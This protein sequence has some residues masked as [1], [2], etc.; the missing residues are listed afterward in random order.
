VDE[1]AKAAKIAV[2]RRRVQKPKGEDHEF[3]AVFQKDLKVDRK[4]FEGI[5][6]NLLDSKP[7]KRENV[8]V[9]KKKPGKLIPPPK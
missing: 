6:K 9:G 8:K 3:Q 2:G 1:K 5:V 7:T 4:K